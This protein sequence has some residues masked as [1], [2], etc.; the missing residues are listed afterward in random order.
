MPQTI[1]TNISSLLVNHRISYKTFSNNIGELDVSDCVFFSTQPAKV[2]PWDLNLHPGESL[3]VNCTVND[4]NV[5]DVNISSLYFWRYP[6]DGDP[7]VATT[8]HQAVGNN[9]MQIHLTNVN[10]SDAGFY[11]CYSGD[12]ILIARTSCHVQIGGK[13]DLIP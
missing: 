8:A 5:T 11:R 13:T 7:R 3:I 4:D 9:I 12:D 1:D 2:R 6:S 10:M